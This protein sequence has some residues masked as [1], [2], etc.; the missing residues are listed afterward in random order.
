MSTLVRTAAGG[1][2]YTKGAS[3]II[4]DICTSYVD[5][6]GPPQTL[7]RRREAFCRLRQS[8]RKAARLL[9]TWCGAQDM[10][11]RPL[12]EAK[13]QEMLAQITA[14]ASQG[15]RT[16]ALAYRDINDVDAAVNSEEA[17]EEELTCIGIVGIKDPLRKEVPGAVKT[18]QKVRRLRA[19]RRLCA[20][21]S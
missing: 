20:A 6:V 9:M 7:Q 19:G 15:L 4:V 12:D 16:I 11:V 14:M 18:C 3:E 17:P 10:V 13:R 21:P 1:C 8:C 2:L 5:N